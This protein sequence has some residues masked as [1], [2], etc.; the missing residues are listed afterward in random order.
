MASRVSAGLE[1][2]LSDGNSRRWN[3]R[4][5]VSIAGMTASEYR[6]SARPRTCVLYVC[7][8]LL[9]LLAPIGRAAPPV[10][11]DAQLAER[12]RLW[13][14]YQDLEAV[15]KLPE[16]TRALEQ[17][18]QIERRLY[19]ESEV[20]TASTL[21]SLAELYVQQDQLPEAR[22]SRQDALKV[23]EA[24][25][26]K[27]HWSAT[28]ARLGL[29]DV[30]RLAELST[31]ERRQLREATAVLLNGGSAAIDD[32]LP[33]R[34]ERLQAALATRQRL[35][36]AG[37]YSV[38]EGWS[39]L[40]AVRALAGQYEQAEQCFQQALSIRKAALGELHPDLAVE[41]DQ[42]AD[43]YKARGDYARA[44]PLYR[45]ALNVRLRS[46][47]AVDDSIATSW[48]QLGELYQELG[49]FARADAA[50]KAALSIHKRSSGTE[51]V[52]YALA[53]VNLA[54][55]YRVQGD[56]AR[57]EPLLLDANRILRA[58]GDEGLPFW[59]KCLNDLAMLYELMGDHARAEPL[60][61]QVVDHC[62]A[63]LGEDHEDYATALHNLA[64]LY[65]TKRKLELAE[66]LLLQ[67][68][69]IHRRALGESHPQFAQSLDSLASLH[70]FQ[71]QPLLAAP[72]YQQSLKIKRRAF[73]RESRQ[74]ALA[75]SNLAA[76]T[77]AQGE[78]QKAV[79]Q[80]QQSIELYRKCLGEAHPELIA[81]MQ[82]QA[83][84]HFLLRDD[85]RAAR[86]A[87]DVLRLTRERL[88]RLAVVQSER[89]QLASVEA[90]RA[91][92]ACLLTSTAQSGADTA[93]VYT[94]VLA[95]K[96]AVSR[97]QQQSRRMA[98]LAAV[99]DPK[100]RDLL[101]AYRHAVARLARLAT[102]APAADQAGHRRQVA[103][104]SG[105]IEQFEQ[106]LVARSASFRAQQEQGRLTSAA[107]A[108][109]LPADCALVDIVLYVHAAPSGKPQLLLNGEPRAVAF[110]SRRDQPV[111]RIELG[112]A[113]P[114]YDAVHAWRRR[115]VNDTRRP[116]AVR[117]DQSQADPAA[118][119]RDLLWRPLAEAVGDAEVLL[120]SP[121][122]A[123]A[124]FPW[125]ALQVSESGR[126]LVEDFAVSIV[127]I[128]SLIPQLLS[129]VRL[130][131]PGGPSMLLVGDV[132]YDAS[133]AITAKADRPSDAARSD[134]HWQALPQTEDEVSA[135]RASF[136]QWR[137]QGRA[138]VLRRGE[139]IEAAV[140]SLVG[141]CE[142]LHFA[143]HGYFE[144]DAQRA[145]LATRLDARADSVT[146][147]DV[148]SYHPGLLSGI[149]L[150]G[151]NRRQ[152]GGGDDGILTA[153]EVSAL[154]LSRVRLATLSACETGLGRGEAGEGLLG[155]QRA[156]QT[157]GAQSVLSSL[158]LV[159]DDATRQ[160]M[161]DFYDNL[162]T[163]GLSRCQALR[164]AQLTMLR[165]GLRPTGKP[166][167]QRGL[168]VAGD[169]A[170]RDPK[171]ARQL[172][173]EF[174]APFV[175]SGD[176]R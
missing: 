61:Q 3:V 126:Y 159:R 56:Y 77:Q 104:L 14:A 36:G 89:Q 43:L 144:S 18:L 49:E 137:K 7:A 113:E 87:R 80:Y 99:D 173:P 53:L 110:V 2:P 20:E 27:G 102:L 39:K 172:S 135:V 117:P 95:W 90:E 125:A 84:A 147:Q 47:D 40:G 66:P 150:A 71:N 23:L 92:M 10:D 100:L 171:N 9:V 37:H 103:D 175:L 154:D 22:R 46:L 153:L 60:Y 21:E 109:A 112:A 141:G 121:D 30:E 24:A 16:A 8:V 31:D 176:W 45:G 114:L 67:A 29:Q 55:M 155:L 111:R 133:A 81:T 129:E 79:D 143:T 169:R 142:Y 42:L 160:L 34:T 156:F 1:L 12:D 128:P 70:L 19:G 123:L 85:A 124:R 26:P 151:A 97:R 72:L 76:N 139:P 38:G 167:G 108:A 136:M 149:V 50:L 98:S 170:A 152:L 6:L 101:E 74:V 93:E 4:H 64:G 73:G 130:Q 13:D 165:E 161:V 25:H 168:T 131:G 166:G 132:D 116:E 158:W 59:P 58:A 15:G 96:G 68:V 107:L 134:A 17:V 32:D 127:P 122:I 5:A 54:T 33:K 105:Q 35:W 106:Q 140:R 65:R 57:C 52:D 115:F 162:W 41:M 120:I 48:K 88:E 157:A 174:W 163:R 83:W 63:T 148:A 44:E 164:R 78:Y 146:A 62:R 119:L 91:S 138:T 82:A 69:E 145:A 86:L 11:E 118:C 28:S 51:S 94:E 75:I